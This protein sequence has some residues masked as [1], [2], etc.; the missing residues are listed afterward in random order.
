[1][2]SWTPHNVQEYY[3]RILRLLH[4]TEG[5]CTKWHSSHSSVK[6][7]TKL[8]PRSLAV[9]DVNINTT[10]EDKI[11]MIPDRLC[12]SRHPNIYMMGFDADLSKR[13]KGYSGT[14]HSNQ[15]ES[16][17]ECKAQ[18]RLA[19]VG[20]THKDDADGQVF[21]IETL[22]TSLRNMDKPPNT[23]NVRFLFVQRVRLYR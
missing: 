20:W 23:A 19:V 9:V 21:Q 7:T 6:Q 8:L 16:H 4:E 14:I 22:D 3:T 13:A 10:S 1:M 12:Q 2:C 17:R 11:R 18:K 5:A 15:S